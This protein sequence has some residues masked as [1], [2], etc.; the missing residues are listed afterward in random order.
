MNK[1]FIN[2]KLAFRQLLR[3]KHITAIKLTGLILGFTL[4][5]LLF[6][7][8]WFEFSYDNFHKNAPNIYRLQTEY[9]KNKEITE[10]YTTSDPAW[11]PV[12]KAEFPEVKDFVRIHTFSRDHVVKLKNIKFRESRIFTTDPAFFRIFDYPIVKGD[13]N[14]VLK[15]PGTMVISE[16]IALK[17]FGSEEPVGKIMEISNGNKF[18][19]FEITGVFKDFPV[20]SNLQYDFIISWESIRNSN[21]SIEIAWQNEFYYTY[22]LLN[23]KASPR[24]IERQSSEIYH[25]YSF[26]K[27]VKKQLH[28]LRL[29]DI[30]L[31]TFQQWEVETKGNRALTWIITMLGFAILLIALINYVNIIISQSIE[32]SKSIGIRQLLG[33]GKVNIID[34]FVQES[35]IVNLIALIISAVIIML[36]SPILMDISVSFNSHALFISL[37]SWII[38]GVE[39]LSCVTITGLMPGIAFSRLNPLPLIKGSYKTSGAGNLFRK[40]FTV[41]Q[42]VIS[43]VFIIATFMVYRQMEFI[44]KKDLGIKMQQMLAVHT[45]VGRDFDISKIRSF[46]AEIIKNPEIEDISLSSDVPGRDASNG[47]FVERGK[48][49]HENL[50]FDIMKFDYNFIPAYGLN[51]IAGRNFSEVPENDK[52]SV[53]LNERAVA[54]L[55]YKPE[56]IVG[57]EIYLTELGN[58]PYKVIGV[59]KNFNQLSLHETYSPYMIMYQGFPWLTSDFLSFKIK[60]ENYSKT[61]AKIEKEWKLFFP[62]STFDYFFVDQFFDTQYKQDWL[63]S[64]VLI[65]FSILSVFISC[66]G[67]FALSLYLTAQ[68]TKEIGIRR[69]NGST[70]LNILTLLS[71]DFTLYVAFAFVI[72]SPLAFWGISVWLQNFP[73]RTDMVWWAYLLA[74]TIVLVIATS[75]VCWQVWQVSNKNPVEVLRYE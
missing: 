3:K 26:M 1:M 64:K 73:F 6:R 44:S 51:I 62:S 32:R 24:N 2:L 19:N 46:N 29:R 23:D 65:L 58:A 69:V 7:Y 54:M 74:G 55:N 60:S 8:A 27:E 68:R 61:I 20:N 31:N 25:K 53:L 15:R 41:F 45:P 16:S 4:S 63:F 28:L 10:V 33:S 38:A 56:D 40:G 12:L 22:V 37:P 71:K 70:Q 18:D 50:L 30:H 42:F 57:K 67:V 66:L 47:L 36:L 34:Y 21:P 9:L 13:F 35:I 14:T 52:T 49:D 59:L 75:T 17:Y 72:A 39:F 48:S 5:L 43:I 11:G